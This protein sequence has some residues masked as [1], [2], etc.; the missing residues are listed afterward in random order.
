MGEEMCIRDRCVHSGRS[1]NAYQD[2]TKPLSLTQ[3]PHNGGDE[4]HGRQD[5]AAEAQDYA[6]PVSY[7]HLDVYKRQLHTGAVV[8][9]H[10]KLLLTWSVLSACLLFSGTVLLL[11]QIRKKE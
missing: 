7:T 6:V 4:D 8:M 5:E 11:Y 2:G 1:D 10:G 9:G 3:H